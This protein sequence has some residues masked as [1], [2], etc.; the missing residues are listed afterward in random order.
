VVKTVNFYFRIEYGSRGYHHG[1]GHLIGSRVCTNR[2]DRR[3]FRVETSPVNHPI[4]Y[5]E[6]K[7]EMF[8]P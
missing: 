6:M 8:F 4:G 7:M 1:Y 3:Q 5:P 2:G